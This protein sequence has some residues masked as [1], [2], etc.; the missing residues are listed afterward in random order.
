VPFV[1]SPEQHG[2]LPHGLPWV[3]H[4]VLNVAQ[5]PLVH[6]PLQHC[7]LV[8]HAVPSALHAG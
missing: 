8:V 3:L 6:V 5:L 4:V 2:V 1:Q 7:A